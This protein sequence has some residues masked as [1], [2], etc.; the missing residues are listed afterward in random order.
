MLCSCSQHRVL[1][2]I[3]AANSVTG[4]RFVMTPVKDMNSKLEKQMKDLESDVEG[5]G[6]RL[7]YLETTAKNSQDHI[8]AMLRGGGTGA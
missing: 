8:T 7:H 4:S 6:K 1:G 3:R 5:L 2:Q